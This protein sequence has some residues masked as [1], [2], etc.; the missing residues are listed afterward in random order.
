MDRSINILG[1][2]AEVFEP[3]LRMFIG[4]KENRNSPHIN[5]SAKKGKALTI[6]IYG[7]FGGVNYWLISPFAA[8]H[9][10]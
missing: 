9:R 4:M 2:L 10:K 5:V 8:C 7:C 1:Q 6:I 3:Y